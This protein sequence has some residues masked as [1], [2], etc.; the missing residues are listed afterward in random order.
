MAFELA[1]VSTNTI[2]IS[3]VQAV[4]GNIEPDSNNLF[5]NA[6]SLVIGNATHTSI[7]SAEGVS[8][9]YLS[10]GNTLDNVTIN[11]TSFQIDGN[12][13]N[14]YIDAF[15]AQFSGTVS[16]GN[17]LDLSGGLFTNG[18]LGTAGDVLHSNGSTLYWA[19]PASTGGTISQQQ[20]TG[21]GSTT[22][23]TFTGGYTSNALTVYLN[24]V[25][26]RN[27]TEANVVSGN[28]F[29]ITPAPAS[30]ALID[31][32][33]FSGVVSN[34]VNVD[35]QYVWTN[36]QT[37]SNTITFSSVIN[38]TANNANNLGGTAAANFV[39]NTD[40]RT[41]SGNLTFSG[42][43]RSTYTGS[44]NSSIIVAGTNTKGGAGY[45]DF[46]SAS[47]G[48]A[49]VTNPNKSFRINSTGG[50]EIVNSAYNGVP[51][52]LSDSGNLSISGT[53]TTS[54]RGISAASV[55]TGS[56]LQVVTTNWNGGYAATS[57]SNIDFTGFNATFT[58]L[59]SSSKVLII[60]SAGVNFLCDGSVYIK[61]NGTIIKDNWFGSSRQNDEYDYPQATQLYLDSPGTT[62]T[63]TYQMG[64]RATGC[65]NVIRF[66]AS[67][68]TS[69]I[70]FMEIAA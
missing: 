10:I 50:L 56:V 64:G 54:S 39:Q 34:I 12:G 30:G 35:A 32:I 1:S 17:D 68:N 51:F 38:G 20:F 24:G 53:L 5:A 55:P 14:T 23:F 25:L 65:S 58:P 60:V 36:T 2:T 41:L 27:G 19:A 15:L 67:D 63:I 13:A 9:P 45:H 66:G 43:I 49:G 48:G 70:T 59:Y 3:T 16:V 11:S 4:D 31:A 52:V 18:S 57:A 28:T 8:S 47:N 21:D 62:S 69:S 40:S 44:S 22:T 6:S 61:R 37:F 42:L 46:L 33:G 7:I 29:T 26:L